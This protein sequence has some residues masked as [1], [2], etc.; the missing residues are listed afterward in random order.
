MV[1]RVLW[2]SGWLDAASPR[3]GLLPASRTITWQKSPL[4]RCGSSC[5]KQTGLTAKNAT[6]LRAGL[7]QPRARAMLLSLPAELMHRAASPDIK[8]GGGCPIRTVR[9]GTG[10]FADLPDASRQS[11]WP[12]ARSSSAPTGSPQ[13][14]DHAPR[15]EGRR[16]QKR[17]PDPLAPSAGKRQA[18][19][20]VSDALPASPGRS[21]KPLSLRVERSAAFG[22]ALGNTLS[23]II[24]REIGVEFNVHLAR[25]FAAWNFIQQ[26]PGQYEV[27]RQVL[28]HRSIATTELTTMWDW[29]LLRR[30]CTSTP[31]FC[32]TGRRSGGSQP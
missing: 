29:K 16:D 15:H 20:D 24:T 5:Q 7:M 31:P 25:H 12:A 26:N 18:H 19:R 22:S 4:G 9:C 23:Q 3:P 28:R 2:P 13:A 1:G 30:P 6:R 10:G 21:R 27:V 11:G 32:G 17:Q 8:P 14:K